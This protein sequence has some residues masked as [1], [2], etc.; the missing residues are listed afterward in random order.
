MNFK[1]IIEYEM[2]ISRLRLSV[3]GLCVLAILLAMLLL[4]TAS[5]LEA[6]NTVG[7]GIGL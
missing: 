1:E 5:K 4:S 2:T 6:C 3:L 7:I